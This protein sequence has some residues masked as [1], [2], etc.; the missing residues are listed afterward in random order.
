LPDED[1]ATL[2]GLILHE[3]QIIPET[4][5]SFQFHGFRFD[6]ERRQRNQIKVIRVKPLKTEPAEA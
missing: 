1:Y 2:A 4:G 6:I 3:S 5:Q